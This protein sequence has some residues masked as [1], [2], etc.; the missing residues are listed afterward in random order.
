M[1]EKLSLFCLNYFKII[2]RFVSSV[3]F[4]C[5]LPSCGAPKR[6]SEIGIWCSL[7]VIGYRFRG[8]DKRHP[9]YSIFKW[10]LGKGL[11]CRGVKPPYAIETSQNALPTQ[12]GYLF[13]NMHRDLQETNSEGISFGGYLVLFLQK[14]TT[15][16]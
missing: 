2:N 3:N 16:N 15:L 12:D 7:I 13:L 14:L 10:K 8:R 4:F 9:S 1:N 11:L 5:S 6:L